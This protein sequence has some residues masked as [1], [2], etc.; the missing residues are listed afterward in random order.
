MC[1]INP[2]PVGVFRV[3][4][5]KAKLGANA[6]GK[7]IAEMEMESGPEVKAKPGAKPEVRAEAEKEL[8]VSQTN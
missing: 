2:C 3:I 8:R 5:Q 1:G 7:G 6:E 4:C